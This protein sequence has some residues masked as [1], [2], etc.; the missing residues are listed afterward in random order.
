[1]QASAARPA[2][3]PPAARRVGRTWVLVATD[4]IGRG[5]DFLGVNTVVNFDFPRSTTDYIHRIGR[6]GRAGRA[7]ACRRARGGKPGRTR[8]ASAAAAALSPRRPPH[9]PT[10]TQRP[11]ARR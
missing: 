8:G 5:M 2:P 7:G 4:L 9:T 11:Q 6:T 10:D 1:M 3:A